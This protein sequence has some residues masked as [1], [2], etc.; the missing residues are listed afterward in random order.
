MK[1]YSYP[2]MTRTQERGTEK[3]ILHV[4]Q[5]QF[6]DSEIIVLLGENG[7][8]KTTFVRMLA[9]L[10]KSD[11][12]EK[13]EKEGYEY[14]ASLAGVPDLNVSYKP[15][16]ISPKFQG[17]VRQLLHKRIREFYVHPQFISDVM[18]PLVM[19]NIIDN[20]VQSLSGGELQRLAITLA[21]GTPADVYLLDEPSAYLDS[22]QR[23]NCAKVIKRF[24]MHS[25]K[26]AFIVEH[27]FI[28]ATYLAD[29]VVVYHGQPGIEATATSPQSLLTGMNQFLQ[30]LQVTFRRDPVNYRPR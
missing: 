3:F 7:T 2:A 21:L 26:T 16:K 23:I 20:G 1:E 10:Q 17:T 22:E 15:Q 13:L 11:E 27:D 14:E 25:K 18:K 12:Q 4:E 5:G 8:G 24:I 28:M 29:R 19:D 30:S 9:G 6:T